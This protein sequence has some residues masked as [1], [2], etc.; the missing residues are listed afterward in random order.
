MLLAASL[1]AATAHADSATTPPPASATASDQTAPAAPATAAAAAPTPGA[2]TT[3]APA[4]TP[5]M[6]PDE[7]KREVLEEVRRELEKTKSDIREEVQY[8]E[9]EADAR[10]YDAEQLKQLKET[11]NL[12]QVHGY[13]RTR[14]DLFTDA[15]LGQPADPRATT[16]CSPRPTTTSASPI[17]GCG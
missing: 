9:S 14:G 4:V 15:N 12:F 3:P 7:L 10:N 6:S 11:V 17:C 13:M 2:A 8:V 16:S 5:P 1:V